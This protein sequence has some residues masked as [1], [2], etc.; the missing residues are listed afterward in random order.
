M[1]L[2]ASSICRPEFRRSSLVQRA[3]LA[4]GAVNG[5]SY[6]HKHN[7]VH[8]DLKP[9]NL[10]LDFPLEARSDFTPS[11]KVA[12]FGL[13]KYKVDKYASTDSGLRYY[14]LC[15]PASQLTLPLS[16]GLYQWSHTCIV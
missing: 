16:I 10:L 9:E 4:R 11:I 7:I 13:S 3:K 5:L 1:A 15:T 8:F 12:D 2:R 14:L 6:L